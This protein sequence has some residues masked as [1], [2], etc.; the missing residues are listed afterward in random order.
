M[1]NASLKEKFERDGYIVVPSVFS[2]AEIAQFRKRAYTQ[3]A[4]D[5]AAGLKYDNKYA[6]NAN[7][8]YG[9][10][11]SKNHLR[12]ILMDERILQIAKALLGEVVIYFGDSNYNLGT[13]IRGFHR[14]NVDRAY[15]GG[16]DWRDEYPILRMGVYL[17]DHTLHSGGLK[18]RAGS[19]K[20]ESGP[21]HFVNTKPGDVAVWSLR[22]QH[23]G[24]AVKI[25][26]FPNLSINRGGME[27]AIP[28]F[29][30]REQEA[31]RISLFLSFARKAP[32]LDRYI[33]EYMQRREDVRAN[34]AHSKWPEVA[35]Q[36]AQSRGVELIHTARYEPVNAI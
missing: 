6:P 22:T 18:V 12:E 23:S 13:G 36:L 16:P 8:T 32:L 9:D 31:E 10:L 21:V 33:K 19:H 26:G 1:L 11:L 30:K 20:A 35:K 7:F 4:E 2:E 3:F 29:L 17:Q 5:E 27:G 34:V 14:D 24:N 25:K 15:N 28:N